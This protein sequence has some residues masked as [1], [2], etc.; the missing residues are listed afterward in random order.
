MQGP[1]IPFKSRAHGICKTC[2]FR[3]R[4]DE[5]DFAYA[6]TPQGVYALIPVK[7]LEHENRMPADAKVYRLGYCTLTPT[8]AHVPDFH[9]CGYYR[10][11]ENNRILECNDEGES[12]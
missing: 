4:I 9:Y 6:P 12:K 10:D 7:D 2:A 5:Q 1:I 3:R 11:D 8:W